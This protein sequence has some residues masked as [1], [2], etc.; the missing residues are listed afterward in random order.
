MSERRITRR[1]VLAAGAAVAVAG[2]LGAGATVWSWWDR[3]AG[4]GLKALSPEEHAFVQALA[5]AWMPRGGRPELSGA[6]ARIGDFFDDIIAS[7]HPQTGREMRLL[8][9]A[10]DHL[11]VPRRGR[12]FT[13]L[14][15]QTR[16]EVLAN[17]L[18]HPA[19]LVRDGTAAVMVM[20]GMGWTTHPDVAKVLRPMFPCGYGR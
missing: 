16:S 11:C 8:L 6:D 5:E 17:W 2:G 15:L 4:E 18:D 19:F 20:V 12:R 10:L 13:A 9:H 1:Q 3:P 14:P 7:M